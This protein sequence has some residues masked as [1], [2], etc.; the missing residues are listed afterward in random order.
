MEVHI[1][2]NYFPPEKFDTV[3]Q[4]P[5]LLKPIIDFIAINDLSPEKTMK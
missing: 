3:F 5:L 2:N 4:K 1:L